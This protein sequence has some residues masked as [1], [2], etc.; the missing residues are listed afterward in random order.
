M[1]YGSAAIGQG[2][3]QI[4][5]PVRDPLSIYLSNERAKSQDAFKRQQLAAQQKKAQDADVTR[6]LG[7][8][9]QDPG[10]LFKAWG[11]DITTQA[12]Q[13]VMGVLQANEGQDLNALRPSII[14]IQGDA[15]KK[16]GYAS[17]IA[18][19]YKVKKDT[20]GEIKN[21][22]TREAERILNSAVLGKSDPY[23]VDRE[24]LENVEQV[25]GIYDLNSLVADSV[26]GIK[27]QFKGTNVGAIESS[28]LG[29]FMKV[30]DYK[31]RFKDLNKAM[32]YILRGDDVTDVG[33]NQ[34]I[35]GGIISDRI[36][37]DIAKREVGTQGGDPNDTNQ[38]M[39]RFKD[40]QYDQSY[41]P[42]VRQQLRGILQQFQQEERDVNIQ[43]MGKFPKDGNKKIS[44]E[45]FT[46]RLQTIN[47]VL[48]P[49]DA[50]GNI[51]PTASEAVARLRGGKLGNS[52]I[53]DVS[54]VRG[55]RAYP[56]E[57]V[58]Q[59]N[60][61]FLNRDQEAISNL[62]KN[63]PKPTRT[64]PADNAVM[65]IQTGTIY[66]EPV[67]GE[68]RIDLTDP[69]SKALLNGILTTNPN[70]KKILYPDLLKFQ[71]GHGTDIGILDE[72]E[73]EDEIELDLIND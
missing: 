15:D 42:Q 10:D 20:L 4:Y 27:G 29:M 45:D 30:E 13:A 25:P 70:E 40:I 12:N 6:I 59:L 24:L 9:Y 56:K 26:D 57:F 38:V 55:G 47:T 3:A 43:Q 64:A 53:K 23:Q 69:G 16:L 7:H 11:S 31:V 62:L 49:F 50:S 2:Q 34:K 1:P 44:P 37:W 63:T 18:N 33:I 5:G 60:Q 32:D 52:V 58:Q 19:I 22:D 8:K 21:V 72:E 41:A 67:S 17:E 68:I 65:V 66:G 54:F 36:R 48:N 46:D 71:Q 14:G 39:N 35:N 73:G 61:A 51:S 28:P